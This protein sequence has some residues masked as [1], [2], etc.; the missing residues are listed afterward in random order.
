MLGIRQGLEVDAKFFT[1]Q[2]VF[3]LANNGQ[4]CGHIV[5]HSFYAVLKANSFMQ[6]A[7]KRLH[8]HDMV[9]TFPEGRIK[10]KLARLIS[11]NLH[12]K[13]GGCKFRIGPAP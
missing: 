8:I 12:A 4:W 6:Q 1:C 3:P 5:F 9:E 11:P 7:F 2:T 13:H 10:S